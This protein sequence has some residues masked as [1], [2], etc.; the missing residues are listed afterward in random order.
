MS[1]LGCLGTKGGVATST[2]AV[3]TA[4]SA[5]ELHGAAILVDFAG[6]AAE[7]AGVVGDAAGVFEAVRHAADPFDLLVKT[8]RGL[9]AAGELRVL[10]RGGGRV[11]TRRDGDAL[12][13]MWARLDADGAA[14][15]ADAG[16]GHSG[17]LML[18]DA[19]MRRMVVSDLGFAALR[20]GCGLLGDDDALVVRA[21]DR[22]AADVSDAAEVWGRRADVA[23]AHDPMVAQMSEA[24]RIG[25]W[26]T[27][28]RDR[29]DGLAGL[30]QA[31][32]TVQPS[33]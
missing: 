24:G 10:P 32:R 27:A 6:D 7:M 13:Q 22:F 3:L 8:D 23:V 17:A 33:I 9:Q 18:A 28:N 14:L 25:E 29:L 26:A 15:I 31:T 5:A 20:A 12:A 4:W 19:P 21:D 2:I 11:D 30:G 1:G 16:H